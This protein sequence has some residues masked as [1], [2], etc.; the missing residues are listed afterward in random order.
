VVETRAP[1]EGGRS[2]S[3]PSSTPAFCRSYSPT[4]PRTARFGP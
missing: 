4:L 2:P 3:N 1:V